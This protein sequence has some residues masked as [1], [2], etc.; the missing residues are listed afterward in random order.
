MLQNEESKTRCTMHRLFVFSLYILPAFTALLTQQGNLG[1]SLR[2]L[3]GTAAPSDLLRAEHKR[4]SSVD[5]QRVKGDN[6]SGEILS[7]IEIDT[8]F[9]IVGTTDRVDLVTDDMIISQVSIDRPLDLIIS[10]ESAP[11]S[12]TR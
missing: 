8:W 9:H 2:G 10:K 5:A 1:S 12:K 3:C 6:G 11:E 7:S 4:L